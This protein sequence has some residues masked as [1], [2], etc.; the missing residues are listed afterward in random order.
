MSV[1]KSSLTYFNE[2]KSKTV[3]WLWYPYIPYGKITIVQGDPGEGKTSF[4]LN[5]IA[6]MSR[7]GCLPNSS[8]HISGVAIYQNAEDDIADTI[9][10]RLERQEAD[11]G[12]ICFITDNAGLTIDN[13]TLEKAI[14]DSK[15]KLL[16]LDPIQSF[17]GENV[18]MNRANS[19]RPKM[20][21]LKETAERTGCAV[22]LVG[23]LNKNTGGKANYRGLGSI[24][25]SAAARSVLLVGHMEE[26]PNLHVLAQQKNNLAPLGKS[27]GFILSKGTLQWHGE[28]DVLADELAN[29]STRVSII[30]EIADFLYTILEEEMLPSQTVFD[31]CSEQGYSKRSVCRAKNSLPIHSVKKTDGWYWKMGE[32]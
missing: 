23:H 13:D 24:D 29:G 1:E 31:L 8:K 5:L 14:L 9:K 26:T 32:V 25:I 27:L 22:I 28:L 20:Q 6:T 12:N 4:I 2:I 18:D 19:I 21:R 11:C 16:V 10:P 15:A 3:K 7:N 30:D 17:L